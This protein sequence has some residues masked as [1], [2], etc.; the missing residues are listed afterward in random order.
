MEHLEIVHVRL[1]REQPD[2]LI[3][4]IHR[5][6]T[7]ARGTVRIYRRADVAGDIGIHLLVEAGPGEARPSELG[8]RL[9]SALRDH[10]MVEHTLW[11]E[12]LVDES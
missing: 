1:T 11:H 8:L 2:Q 12:A 7:A 10:G 3:E 5:S 9:A 6:A 4:D